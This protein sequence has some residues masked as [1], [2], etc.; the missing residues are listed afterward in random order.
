MAA[1]KKSGEGETVTY[2]ARHHSTGE[3]HPNPDDVNRKLWIKRLG[4]WRESIRSR[5]NTNLIYR[6]VLAV[7]GGAIVVG[8]LALVPLP[9]PGWVIVFVGLAIL[10]TEF[11]WAER[12]NAFARRQ[13]RGWT[14]WLGRQALWVRILAGLATFVLVCAIFYGVLALSGVPGWVPDS[15]VPGWP[16]LT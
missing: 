11:T 4:A 2:P 12:L 13:V 9:G 8:G 5:P 3:N 16:G 6:L 15:F 10:A 1:V 14:Q 7:I